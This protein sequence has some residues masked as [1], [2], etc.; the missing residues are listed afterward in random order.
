[1]ISPK[2]L[3]TRLATIGHIKIGGLG[4]MI[5][6]SNNKQFRPP[7]KFDHF[8]ITTNARTDA[9]DL[10]R[11]EEAHKIVG[12][13]PTSL[14]IL[15]LYNDQEL[16]FR[17]CLA[18][19][20]GK[21][22]MCRGDG[23]TAECWDEKTK[24]YVTRDCPCP[25]LNTEENPKGPC[26]PHGKLSCVLEAAQVAGGVHVFDTTSWNSIASIDASLKFLRGCTGG[27]IA[28][29]PLRMTLEKKAVVVMDKP[30]TIFF[31]NLVYK[32]SPIQMLEQAVVQAKKLIDAG[33]SLR[34][35]EAE[36]KHLLTYEGAMNGPLDEKEIPEFFPEETVLQDG[37]K[38]G[39]TT[40]TLADIGKKNEEPSPLTDQEKAAIIKT[41]A[42]EYDQFSQPKKDPPSTEAEKPIEVPPPRGPVKPADQP[43]AAAKFRYFSCLECGHATTTSTTDS[44]GG[45]LSSCKC[46]SPV[47]PKEHETLVLARQYSTKPA[48]KVQP[49][50]E[51]LSPMERIKAEF[52]RLKFT[53]SRVKLHLKFTLGTEKKLEETTPEEQAKLVE[54][55]KVI[56]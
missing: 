50:H 45:E 11:D 52:T 18:K 15:L 51:E 24:G 8:Q 22:C 16:S 49:P 4:K 33:I 39:D 40:A 54:S 5:T 10:V 23:E 29:I 42:A 34:E 55:L 13:K 30:S 36:A 27:R 37:P 7:I 28:G 1:M 21:K 46:G 41:E 44:S 56:K 14:G 31:V 20:A 35:V 47:K 12:D 25:D 32:G 3:R 38:L 53:Q 9:G 6:T 2:V 26:K 48:S 43:A 19:Y 17:T